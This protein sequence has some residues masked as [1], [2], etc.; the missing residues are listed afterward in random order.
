MPNEKVS[1]IW[2]LVSG[3]KN[4]KYKILNTKYCKADG[5]TLIEFLV[6]L[7]LLTVTVST[8]LLFLSSILRGS[9][10]A[11]VTAEVKQN[12][13]AVLDSLE[14][15]IRNAID[16]EQIGQNQNHI[17]LMRPNADPLHI[18]CIEGTYPTSNDW[19]GVA[20]IKE[21]VP[22]DNDTL[23]MHVTNIDS[24]SGVSADEC[25]L[26]V[27]KATEGAISPAVVSV[28]FVLNQGVQ[29]PSRQDFQANA[30]FATTISLRKY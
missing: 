28:R 7:G 11:N 23:Y 30:K 24:I 19:I 18:R 1:G 22:D 13:Q 16:A 10:Q 26:V 21:G 17:K 6:V 25:S 14:R 8:T 12:G 20:T 15:Q 2:Y 3:I 5:F 9:N 4:T 27:I 29:A